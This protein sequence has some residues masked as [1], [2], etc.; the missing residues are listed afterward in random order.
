MFCKYCGNRIADGTKFCKYCGKSI[1]PKRSREDVPVRPEPAGSNSINPES[2]RRE[3][4]NPEPRQTFVGEE[5]ERPLYVDPVRDSEYVNSRKEPGPGYDDLNEAAEPEYG[6]SGEESEPEGIRPDKEARAYLRPGR[7]P[8]AVPERKRSRDPERDTDSERR[9]ETNRAGQSRA[10]QDSNSV[11]NRSRD[12]DEES[13][14]KSDINKLLISVIAL[15]A[16]ILIVT[17]VL[18]FLYFRNASSD[19]SEKNISE[20]VIEEAGNEEGKEIAPEETPSAEKTLFEP[21]APAPEEPAPGEGAE[22]LKAEEPAEE[23]SEKNLDI[24]NYEVFTEDI[25]WTEA[26]DRCRQKGGYLARIDSVDEY[27][28]ICDLLNSKGVTGIAY[29]G[30]RRE[31]DS[32]KYA[33]VGNDGELYDYEVS[34]DDYRGVWLEGEP[35]YHDEADG[36]SIDECYMA[37]LY[38]KSENRWYWNDIAND[39]LSIAPD[40]YNGKISYICEYE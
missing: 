21:E 16:L 29:I 19:P 17:G 15:L 40:Y 25:T 5:P 8:E 36:K 38:R 31:P 18:M 26:Y 39:V 12:R 20:N 37:M 13:D 35:S 33:W 34:K 10:D 30:G 22:T 24:H 6:G 11:R 28:V 9:R 27:N 32:E 3:P 7:R 23:V 2:L 14:E 4:D 1:V